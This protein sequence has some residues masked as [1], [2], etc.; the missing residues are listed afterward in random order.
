MPSPHAVQ[1]LVWTENMRNPVGVEVGVFVGR[2][3]QAL[4]AGRGALTLHMVD[5]WAV[6]APD[7][8]YAHTGDFHAALTQAQQDK[9]Y[10]TACNAVQFAGQRAKVMR[11][12]SAAAA[13]TF[14][15][16]SLDFVFIDADHSFEGCTADIIA[17]LPKVKPG[18]FLSGHDYNNHDYPMFGVNRAVDN[19]FWD[20]DVETGMGTTW[21]VKCES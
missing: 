1:L 3:S 14:K 18:G 10:K 12:A 5:S 13:A 19:F 9:Y 20:R 4:L 16:K 2:T 15:D 8:S 17:W 21:R 7:A 6:C 11:M